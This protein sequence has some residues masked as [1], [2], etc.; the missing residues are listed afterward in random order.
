MELV[1]NGVSREEAYLIVQKKAMQSWK[2]NTSFLKA[3]T[4]DPKI[5]KKI[6]VSKLKK[7]FDFSYHTKKINI[8]FNRSIK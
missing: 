8:I 2:S 7:L 5:I 4:T 6:P 3:L 1:N